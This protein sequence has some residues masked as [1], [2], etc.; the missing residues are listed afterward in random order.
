[1]LYDAE[2]LDGTDG[3]GAPPF[4]FAFAAGAEGEDS[5]ERRLPETA[6][7]IFHIKWDTTPQHVPFGLWR[8]IRTS[9]AAKSAS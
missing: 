3:A 7:S 4:L 9:S 1:M 2:R 5:T 8:G 6:F